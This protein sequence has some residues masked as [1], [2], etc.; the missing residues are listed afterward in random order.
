MQRDAIDF[1]KNFLKY[2]KTPKAGATLRVRRLPGKAGAAASAVVSAERSVRQ[3][4]SLRTKDG[5]CE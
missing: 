1:K 3:E 4:G 2:L 5:L